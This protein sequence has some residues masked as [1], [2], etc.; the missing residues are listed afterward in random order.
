MHPEYGVQGAPASHSRSRVWL[1]MSARVRTRVT[2]NERR[3]Y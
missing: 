1:A 3:F 2:Q